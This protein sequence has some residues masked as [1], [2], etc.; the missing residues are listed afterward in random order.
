MWRFLEGASSGEAERERFW[1][2]KRNG[3]EMDSARS[4]VALESIVV[5]T[6]S[7]GDV[8]PSM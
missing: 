2:L 5:E 7:Q 1:D 6:G 8:M 3:R 4:G